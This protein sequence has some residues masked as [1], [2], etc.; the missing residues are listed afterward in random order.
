MFGFPLKWLDQSIPNLKLCL[1][2]LHCASVIGDPIQ[3]LLLI[4]ALFYSRQSGTNFFLPFFSTQ[5]LIMCVRTCRYGNVFK[6]SIL[7]TGVIVSTDP[8]VNKVILQNHGSIFIPAYPKSI[9]ELMGEHSI[10]QM[11]GNMHRKLHALLGGF[12]RSP[13]F[14][15]RITRDI[16]HSVKQCL[17]SWT[18]QPIYVQDQVKKVSLYFIN[19]CLNYQMTELPQ[20]IVILIKIAL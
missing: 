7:G 6:T 18:P 4:Q 3:H 20:V 8:D 5:Y 15:A 13:Q 19:A 17:A 11:N 16:E 10:L 1:Q 9:R 12:L 2:L 14:K